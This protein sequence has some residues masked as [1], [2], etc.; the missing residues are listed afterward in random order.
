MDLD[1]NGVN[2]E[3]ILDNYFDSKLPFEVKQEKV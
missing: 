3:E 2:I 1:N